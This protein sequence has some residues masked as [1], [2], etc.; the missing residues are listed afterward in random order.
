MTRSAQRKAKIGVGTVVKF[1]FGVSEVEA[2]VIEDRG[3]VGVRG[4]RILRV[5]LEIEASDPLEFEVPEDDV[6]V[7]A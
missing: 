1:M 7:A 6:H 3:P 2:T 5:R 4:R